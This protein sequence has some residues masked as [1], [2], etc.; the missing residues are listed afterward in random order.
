MFAQETITLLQSKKVDY[1]RNRIH[2]NDSIFMVASLFYG[3]VYSH[4]DIDNISSAIEDIVFFFN[5]NNAPCLVSVPVNYGEHVRLEPVHLINEVL[6]TK[7]RSYDNN[8]ISLFHGLFDDM[9]QVSWRS[10]KGISS[11]GFPDKGIVQMFRVKSHF[12]LSKLFL[13]NQSLCQSSKSRM[14]VYR[15]RV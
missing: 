14:D 2:D 11:T 12:Y 9:F 15:V 13:R 8:M 7:I 6:R 5:T 4:I 1:G 10:R 3:L